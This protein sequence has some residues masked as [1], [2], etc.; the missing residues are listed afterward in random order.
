[1]PGASGPLP[2]TRI[3]FTNFCQIHNVRAQISSTHHIIFHFPV[4][5]YCVNVGLS[6]HSSSNFGQHLFIVHPVEIIGSTTQFS[7]RLA[8]TTRYTF[9]QEGRNMIPSRPI[10]SPTVLYLRYRK[11]TN[12]HTTTTELRR[13]IDNPSGVSGMFQ[14]IWKV[15][16]YPQRSR[17]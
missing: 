16:P 14:A 15:L 17:L 2:S 11:T 1:M 8:S 5:G 9:L 10:A 6:R 12:Q 7:P 13:G 3:S 4:P